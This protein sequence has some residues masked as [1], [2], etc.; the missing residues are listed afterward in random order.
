MAATKKKRMTKAE[1]VA[2]LADK[3][4][5]SKKDIQGVLEALRD[6]A[7]KELGRRGPG[8]LVIPDLVKL[9][10]KLTPARKAR[11]GRNPRTGEEITIPARPAQK[12]VKATPIKKLNDLIK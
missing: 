6:I 12:K 9:Q 7:K 11:K 4:D 8:E 3:T 5:L 2:A 1:L 10:V